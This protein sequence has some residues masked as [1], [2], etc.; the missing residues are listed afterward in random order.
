VE[1]V[2]EEAVG[3]EAADDG[4]VDV[5]AAE[6]GAVDEASTLATAQPMPGSAPWRRVQSSDWIPASS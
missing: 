2:G 5:G 4:A 1:A 3:E 6:V